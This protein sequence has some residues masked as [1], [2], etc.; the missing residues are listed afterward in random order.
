MPNRGKNRASKANPS[1]EPGSQASSSSGPNVP[2]QPAPLSRAALANAALQRQKKRAARVTEKEAKS[3]ALKN[4]GNNLFQGG[5]YEG[6][7]EAYQ[8]AIDEYGSTAVL[9]SNL[10]AAY[11]KL[12][13]YDEA[14]DAAL[15]ALVRDP[16]MLKAR[17]R[18]GLARKE[19]GQYTAALADFKAV[20]KQDSTRS[21]ARVQLIATQ[22]LRNNY[23]DDYA[24]DKEEDDLIWPFYDDNPEGFSD[25]DSD[26]S[27]CRH[28]GSG[29][30]CRFYNH[31]G[32]T[33]KDNCRFSHAPDEHSE[34]DKVGRNVCINHLIDKCKFGEAKCVYSHDKT[35][36]PYGWWNNP[37]TI[38]T[39]K[40][41]DFQE[42][43]KNGKNII[44]SLGPR[45]NLPPG[46]A[47][48]I[49]DE[50]S[51]STSQKDVVSRFVLLLALD[52]GATE[53]YKI[54][55]ITALHAETAV[56]KAITGSEALTHLASPDLKGV[57]V[58][59]AAITKR[60]NAQVLTKLVEFTRA[61]GS[62]VFGGS[63]SSFI[64]PP[65][66]AT[67][68]SNSWGLN[69]KSA[70]YHRA[71]FILNR[72]HYIA[73]FPHS[74]PWSYSM[75][76]L[77]IEGFPPSAVIYKEDGANSA[78]SPVVQV[79]VGKGHV[80]YIGDVNW[81][82]SSIKVLL[83]MLSSSESSPAPS[84]AI[85]STST[86]KSS[87]SGANGA[88]PKTPT[89]DATSAGP[90][91]PSQTEEEEEE[92]EDTTPS[93]PEFVLILAL[94]GDLTEAYKR[95]TI[96]LLKTK[97]P[98]K[99]ATIQT[100]ALRL[101]ASD[102]LQGAFVVDAG[103]ANRKNAQTLTKLVEFAKAGGSVIIGG[104][105]ST[106]VK[107]KDMGA[108]FLKSWGVAWKPGSY[109]R[110]TFFLNPA[111]ELSKAN[112]ALVS[113][114][115]MKA[116]HVKDIS[117]DVVV[118]R[119]TGES[120]LESLVFA[121]GL[122]TNLAESPAVRT[123]VGK[124]YLSYIGD[125]N[126]ETGSAKLALA[127]LG[128]LNP[129]LKPQHQAGPSTRTP[130]PSPSTAPYA[131]PTA[132]KAPLVAPKAAPTAPVPKP[133]SSTAPQASPTPSKAPLVTPTVPIKPVDP[134][135]P[136]LMLLSLED[137]DFFATTY[138]HCLSALRDKV[139]IAQAL[140]VSSALTMLDNVNL[141]GVFVTDAGIVK[142][143]HKGLL[144]RLVKY[145]EQGGTVIVGGSFSSFVSAS[146]MEAFFKDTWGI[147]WT[148]GAY[149]RTKFLRNS[150]HEVISK[151]PSLVRSYSMKAL[152]LGGLSV[153]DP[154]YLPADGPHLQSHLPINNHT[155]SPVVLRKIEEGYFGYV[156]DV[157]A[158]PETTS[159]VLA[160]FGLL[161][162]L[163]KG[164]Q[165]EPPKV[166]VPAAQPVDELQPKKEAP[167]ASTSAQKTEAKT[168][169]RAQSPVS[170]PT[171][172]RPEAKVESEFARLPVGPTRRPFMMVMSFGNE[173]FFAG[174]QEDLLELLKS[175]L[176]V[177]HG[178]S[179][180]RVV[181][182]LGSQDLIGV[183]ITDAAIIEPTNAYL[184]SRLVAFAK[185]GGIVVLGGAFSS[186]IKF[187]EMG[188][189]FQDAWGVPWRAGDYTRS[190]IH[191][192]PA[193][194]LSKAPAL[195][196]SFTMKSLFVV[197]TTPETA[198]YVPAKGHATAGKLPQAPVAVGRIGKGRLGYIGDVGLQDEHS[199]IVLAMFGLSN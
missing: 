194:E 189:F 5:D 176:E 114:Y 192:N 23:G 57:F 102:S 34:R 145:V 10:A 60:P 120:R 19:S 84:P 105:F 52:G 74:L 42:F 137:E 33:R 127:M 26:S 178:L 46:F 94:E 175:K 38:A 14:E 1:E 22:D 4:T 98:L 36:L 103:I 191:L 78:E 3:E 12:E 157:D 164:G 71:V 73:K 7:V 15:E 184:L 31:G 135:P 37:T 55:T 72:S 101:L 47:Q 116:L 132:S 87:P 54:P 168:V 70:S 158:E 6:A 88:Q 118:Y 190:E 156:G 18:R 181:E 96:D 58:A 151:N 163:K 65:D 130:Q 89:S 162:D 30:P 50:K 117:P 99:T 100:D 133:S 11:L 92:E 53:E 59:D 155:E 111:H 80:G 45:K 140:T 77:H 166:A 161:E 139:V 144:P 86:T 182:L 17:Y 172:A 44:K 146:D 179:H 174:V 67:F 160:M 91:T 2:S 16:K 110:T 123:H 106:F 69:W 51:T 171:P 128:L 183:F 170:A 143:E 83:A 198:L 108:F 29:V 75:K 129:Q 187:T 180:E 185:A 196:S 13:Q 95:P 165:T 20:L 49:S 159:V 154:V 142:A 131:S 167:V 82:Q 28:I 150:A 186:H 8:E 104:A 40:E 199:K 188:P 41:L 25:T 134:S 109:H 113:S 141:A 115:S 136:S 56:K 169:P 35:F 153:S 148:S 64:R 197:G 79:P 125:V 48:T 152:H 112:P 195:P 76:A 61:G 85:T 149:H 173:K 177:L 138:V 32:C 193:H 107:P 122:V 43:E 27:D 90:S 9:Y 62:V 24:D 119:P 21:E 93:E 39:L 66:L 68:F 126:W 121:P 147:S 81:E 124:G 97:S 63:F